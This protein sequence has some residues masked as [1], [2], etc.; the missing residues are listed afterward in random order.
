MKKQKFLTHLLIAGLCLLML[1]F[2]V[3]SFADDKEQPNN[4]DGKGP[5][6][7]G[8]YKLGIHNAT[9]YYPKNAGAVGALVFC[10]PFTA[11]QVMFRGWG[12]WF[13]SHGI[14]SVLMDT[15]TIMD[16]PDSRATQQ[17]SV[18]SRLKSNPTNKDGTQLDTSRVGV[19][20]WSMGGGATWINAGT[21]SGQVKMAISLAGHN[22]TA[23]NRASKG[24]GI[25]C[26]LLE[27]N[28][29]TDVTILGGLGQS[30]G[31]FRN[32][33]G[34]TVL[35][36]KAMGGHMNWGSPAQGGAGIGGLVLAF[37]KTYL[38]DDPSWASYIKRPTGCSTWR[39]KNL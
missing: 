3:N 4:R 27:L 11:T 12:P 1:S 21:H 5:Y 7:S 18:V 32:A 26:P 14:I 39:T 2:A 13:A 19:M 6:N 35:A 10:P 17:W 8:Q 34:P 22:M 15:T 36:V 30:E 38:N 24:Y 16:Y 20:G 37:T 33:T 9:V 31:V 28:G 23:M 25:S 29:A